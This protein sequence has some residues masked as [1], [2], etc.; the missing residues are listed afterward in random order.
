[1]PLSIPQFDQYQQPLIPLRGLWNK[2]PP[3]GDRYVNAEIDWL[4]TTKGSAVQFSL[5]GNSPVTLS[6]IVAVSV[7]NGR[8]GADCDF[9]FPDS[10]FVLT[11]PAHCQ[12]TFPVFTNALMFYASAP[13]VAAGDTTIIQILNSMPPP[14]AIQ[15]TEQQNHAGISGVALANSSSILIPAGINGTLN[16]IAMTLDGGSVA[17]ICNIILSDG[18]GKQLYVAAPQFPASGAPLT[19]NVPNLNIRFVNGVNVVISASTL[20][21]GLAIVNVYYTSP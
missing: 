2:T 17:G 5:S 21:G 6:Q 4:T 15:Q 11:V 20:T 7:D 9:I 19:I 18:T 14:I 13:G 3:E 1:M 16:T 12:G 10:G 8:C